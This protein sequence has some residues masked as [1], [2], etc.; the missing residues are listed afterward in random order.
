MVIITA[1]D[2]LGEKLYIVKCPACE[3]S[4][5]MANDCECYKCFGTGRRALREHELS[6]YG[7]QVPL[8]LKEH[9]QNKERRRYGYQTIVSRERDRG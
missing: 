2:T 6:S 9:S 1:I 3:G 4:G 5:V 7:F 8:T